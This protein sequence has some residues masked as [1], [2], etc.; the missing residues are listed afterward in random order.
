[1][2]S[3]NES[4]IKERVKQE[5]VERVSELQKITE[6]RKDFKQKKQFQQK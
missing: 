2:K 4:E 5:M 3:Y 6:M 1:M